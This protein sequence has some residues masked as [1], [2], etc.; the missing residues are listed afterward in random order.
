A[1]A[2]AVAADLDGTCVAVQGPPGSGKTYA[3]ARMVLAL[4]AAHRPVGVTANSHKA[5]CRMLEELAAAAAA[6]GVTLRIV[7]KGEETEWCGLDG[8]ERV[9]DATTVE[10]R[11]AEGS[12]DVV[13]G[14]SWLFARQGMAGRLHTLFVDEAGQLSLANTVAVAGSAANLVLLGDPQ[15]LSQPAKGTHPPGAGV[16]ALEHLLSGG[17]T[18]APE[19]GL[20]LATTRRMHPALCRVVSE[21]FYEGR[22][23]AHPSCRQQWIEAGPWAGGAGLRFLG[24]DHLGNRTN[25]AEEAAEV[26][27]G[28]TALLGRGW[29]DQTGR[30]RTLGVADILVVSPYN[31]QVAKLQATLPAGARVG[32]VDRFQGQEAA[33]VLFSMATSSADELPRSLEFLYSLNQLNVAISSA[34]VLAMVLASPALLHARCRTPAQLR[35]VNA[36][37]R[38]AESGRPAAVPAAMLTA[39]VG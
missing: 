29:T 32:T 4:A 24:V 11:L 28:F 5:I 1:A 13:A 35:L 30:N 34:R 36:L 6:V 38:L 18:V 16:S 10:T 3:G 27:R 15:Q 22:L 17:A 25:S 2:L 21:A 33:V 20:F 26:A 9:S 37:C 12:V 31:A 19:R 39:P 7:Q 8:V 14:T 23:E